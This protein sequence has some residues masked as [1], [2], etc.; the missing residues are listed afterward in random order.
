MHLSIAMIPGWTQKMFLALVLCRLL[1]RCFD[2]ALRRIKGEQTSPATPN[3]V[4]VK[5]RRSLLKKSLT[6]LL[7]EREFY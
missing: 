2:F 1:F 6:A 5:L 4:L 7:C 3:L